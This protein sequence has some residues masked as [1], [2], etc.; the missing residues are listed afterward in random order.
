MLDHTLVAL[1]D[2][3]QS[4]EGQKIEKPFGHPEQ[5]IKCHMEQFYDESIALPKVQ[6]IK[7]KSAGVAGTKPALHSYIAHNLFQIVK[8]DTLRCNPNHTSTSQCQTNFKTSVFEDQSR[9]KLLSKLVNYTYTY[10]NQNDKCRKLLEDILTQATAMARMLFSQSR[11][12]SQ[13]GNYYQAIAKR[14]SFIDV[15]I[16][17]SLFEHGTLE[18]EEKRLNG[19]KKTKPQ[20]ATASKSD[21]QLFS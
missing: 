17:R 6:I 18:C 2:L 8:D 15:Y 12:K 9:V 10:S 19:T 4:G 11:T 21:D 13:I 14:L 3:V 20:L 16:I 1:I 5:F 7:F